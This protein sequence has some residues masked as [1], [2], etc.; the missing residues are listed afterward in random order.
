MAQGH[1]AGPEFVD[2]FEKIHRKEKA[3]QE[4]T[5][6]EHGDYGPGYDPPPS[7]GA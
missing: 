5:L 2:R 3:R 1:N 4:K 6:R 7:P